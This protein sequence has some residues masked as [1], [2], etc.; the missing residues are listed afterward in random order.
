MSADKKWVRIT[1]STNIPIREG[2]AV[3][4]GDR[5]IAIFNLGER[6]LAVESRCPHQGGPLAD[7]ILSGGNVVCP[8]HAWRVD[9]QSG[10]VVKPATGA[11]CVETFET[12]LQDGVVQIALP[13]PMQT[14][15]VPLTSV[16]DQMCGET[17]AIP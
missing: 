11:G 3:S 5:E 17:P 8:L 1:H 9:L 4:V 12:R 14:P 13:V 15:A 2:R 16:S 6:F 7:G 10:C